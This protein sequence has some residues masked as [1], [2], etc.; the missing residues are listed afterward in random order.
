MGQYSAQPFRIGEAYAA[1]VRPA[2]ETY[3]RQATARRPGAA[4]APV[5]E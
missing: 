5:H 1:S 2:R 4:R 3:P